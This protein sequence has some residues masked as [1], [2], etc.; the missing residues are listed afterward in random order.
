MVET[1]IKI[2]LSELIN[3]LV[4]IQ[5]SDMTVRFYTVEVGSIPW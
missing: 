3:W 4:C 5:L 1:L 2:N